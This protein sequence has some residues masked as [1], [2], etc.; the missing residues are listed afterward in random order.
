MVMV[1]HRCFSWVDHLYILVKKIAL[2][3]W[4]ITRSLTLT[5]GSI[6]KNILSVLS[7]N[8][9]QYHV[10]MHTYKLDRITGVRLNPERGV[11]S[12]FEEYQLLSPY[13]FA[14]DDQ[15]TILQQLNTKQYFT[16]PDPWKN[17]YRSASFFILATYSKMKVTQLLIDGGECYD[18]VMFLRPDVKYLHEF[19]V[20]VLSSINSNTC[21]MPDF[22]MYGPPHLKVNDRFCV[23]DQATAEKIGL[24]FN[25]LLEFSKNNQIHSETFLSRILQHNNINRVLIDGFK[26]QR[27]RADGQ[28]PRV[29]TNLM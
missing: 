22:H 1:N 6:D 28:I 12:K 13:R 3:F 24:G 10:Y 27:V 4:G 9:I 20:S 23:C 7:R 25:S 18:Y 15:Q 14:W 26:F 21:A 11:K 8:N 2:C 16:K 19:P 29:D 17:N 5:H